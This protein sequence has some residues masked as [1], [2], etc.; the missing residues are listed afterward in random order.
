M[1]ANCSHLIV[2]KINNLKKVVSSKIKRK[3]KL[4]T[5][6]KIWMNGKK[7]SFG[8][9]T[10]YQ[11]LHDWNSSVTMSKYTTISL[12][13]LPFVFALFGSWYRRCEECKKDEFQKN[14][15]CSTSWMGRHFHLASLPAIDAWPK[16]LMDKKTE[17]NT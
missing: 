7:M 16:T 5:I 12:P 1:G 10:N 14:I 13:H 8:F 4:I 6:T 11:Y 17:I 2:H 9:V 3:I 15:L